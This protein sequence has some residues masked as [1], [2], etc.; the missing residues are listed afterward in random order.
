M[1]RLR[2]G[3]KFSAAITNIGSE[4]RQ[5]KVF[6]RSWMISHGVRRYYASSR[7]PICSE[8][9]QAVNRI[10][11]LHPFAVPKNLGRGLWLNADCQCRIAERRALR[12]RLERVAVKP[13]L[14]LPMPP[15]LRNHSFENFV[16][17]D[18]NREAYTVCLK[19]A[20]SFA[21]ITDGKGVLI[22]GKAGRGKTHLACAVL[23]SLKDRHTIGFA[24]V[25]T[26]LELLRRGEGDIQQLIAVDL[27]ALDDLGSERESDWALEK[28]LVIVDGRLN[29][30][31][32]TIY[33]TNFNID[34]LE[35]RL[36]SRLASRVLYNSHDTAVLGPDWR[37]IK[38]R[39]HGAFA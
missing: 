28:L 7:M 11:R 32:P 3:G 33:T 6:S 27:L 23:N 30:Y 18:F 17:K 29:Q 1:L 12:E 9:R 13:A 25:P 5:R 26:L 10:Y 19:F 2:S 14:N 39:G 38:Y 31:K 15:A 20:A 36:G 4:N 37:E 24:H 34:E 35:L 8:C 21:K 16:V 22:C